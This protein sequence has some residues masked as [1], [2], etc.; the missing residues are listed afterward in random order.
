MKDTMPQVAKY[1]NDIAQDFDAIYSGKKST[2]GRSLDRW[3]RRDIYQR[4]DWVMEQAG[5][6]RGKAVCDIGCGSGR[7]VAELAR[8]GADRVVGVDV[9]PRMLE[10]A[11]DLTAKA[12]VANRCTFAN[13]DVLNWKTTE[14]FDLTI[15]IG[16]WDYIA[17]PRERLR[18]IHGF[19][20][21]TFLS[22][23]P[24]LWTWRM[25]IRK[26]RLGVLGC[27]VYFFSKGQVYSLL[28][29]S[30]FRV[31]SCE[32]IGKLFCVRSEPV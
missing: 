12:G 32:V 26:V 25:P 9:A 24:R 23:W 7:F 28:E 8:R 6:V 16:F 15:A 2:F 13:A 17:D 21:E 10:L 29:S 5:D 11:A 4:F 14:K 22:A 31:K 1:W 20:R 19:T 27:P 18:L 3:L 30:G